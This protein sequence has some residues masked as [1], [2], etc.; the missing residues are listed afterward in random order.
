MQ[1]SFPYT[2][3]PPVDVPDG[4]LRGIFGTP[5]ADPGADPA[6]LTA[7]AIARPIGGPPLRELAAGK[8]RVL[9]VCDD[10]SRPTPVHAILPPVL[11]ALHDAGVT[12]VGIE[13]MMALGTH[14]AMTR[15]EMERKLGADVVAKYPV[16]NHDWED[17][18]VCT[19]IGKTDQD[20]DVWINRAVAA[21]DLV[22]GIGR[23]MPID[24]CGFTGGG[25]ILIPGVCGKSTNDDMHWTRI[26]LDDRAFLGERDNP[27]RASIDALA[28]K[29]G[30]GFIVNVVMD[31][32][33]TVAHVVAGDLVDAHRR[34]CELARNMHGVR[35]PEEEDIVIAD[36]YPFDIEFWQANKALDQAGLVVKEGGVLILVSPCHEGFS[37]TH[38]E[39]LEFGYPPIDRIR[40]L[41]TNGRI[42]SKVVGVHMA[43][44]SR[45]ARDKAHV[46]LVTSGIPREDVERA[47]LGYADTP[48]EAL[49]AA[50]AR[51]GRDA[52]V[53]VLKGAAEML[54][55]VY[56]P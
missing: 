4:N 28:H 8:G 16:H 25:K 42:L 23:I 48:Q 31:S 38:T 5:E 22:I 36:S 44:V 39:I 45:V 55:L 11:E 10:I 35:I 27:V 54:P 37:A 50:F 6:A 26:D 30:L 18:G 21:A 51:M 49:E 29:A 46:I 56:L 13:F 3:V 33:Q 20:V 34:G 7:S 52:G 53:V 17:S 19:L 24:I 2:N 14:R 15:E 43:Q 1:W 41:V 32:N 9:V 12:D 40:D 47:G